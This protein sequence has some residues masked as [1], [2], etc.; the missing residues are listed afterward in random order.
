MSGEKALYFDFS[1]FD[2]N[3]HAIVKEVGEKLAGEALFTAGQGLLDEAENI[4][5]QV[6][7]KTGVL[8]ASRIILPPETS[9]GRIEVR[10]G[11]NKE[12]AAYQHEGERKDGT[13]KV[14][15]YTTDVVT[16]PG[17]K[18]IEAKI[19]GLGPRLLAIMTDYIR[20]KAG[21]SPK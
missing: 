16:Q 10:A 9:E 1:D 20:R 15:N 3:F 11:Y 6:P 19:V 4:P 18:F 14:K 8:R 12:Y 17:A 21:G 13:H 2:K 5:P 7:Q